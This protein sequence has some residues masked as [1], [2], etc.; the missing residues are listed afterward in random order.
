MNENILVVED[1]PA[2]RDALTFRLRDEGYIIHIA[3]D[4]VEGLQKAT[5][6]PFDLIILDVRLPYRNGFEV[7]RLVRENGVATPILML[8]VKDQLFD[9]VLGLNLGADD[10]VTKPFETM[11][12][13]A[14]IQAILRRV[15]VRSGLGVTNFGSICV[16]VPRGKVTRDGEP[17]DLTRREFDLL[18]YLIERAGATVSR[19]ELLR[20]L[21]GY[22]GSSFTRTVDVHVSSLRK[23]LEENPERPE[24][25]RSIHGV[26][27]KFV[28]CAKK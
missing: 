12:L 4:G 20:S 22:E 2:L 25:I 19:T 24:L 9:K 21:W 8:T 27:Y 15:P 26:G 10:Y 1:D 6:R 23:K 11:E 5:D 13:I 17:V 18:C 7:C 28:E 14:R 16:D 3:E